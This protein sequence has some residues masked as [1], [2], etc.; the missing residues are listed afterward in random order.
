MIDLKTVLDPGAVTP[1]TAA[2]NAELEAT[3]AELPRMNTFPPEVVRAARAEGKGALPLLGPREGS[4]WVEIPGAPGGPGRVRISEPD[5]DPKGI[6][7]HIHGGGWTIGAADQYDVVNQSLAKD[8]GLRVVSVA[9]RLAPEH[10]WPAQQL[11]CVAAAKWVM[12]TT[13]LPVFI[14]GE[15]A[16]GH[17]TS[18]VALAMRQAGFA[19]RMRGLVMNYGV[20]DLRGTPS[21][22]NWGER[23]LVLSTPVMDWFFDFV[24]PNGEA[25]QRADLSTLL[26]D[27][28]GMP[29][30]LFQ[31]GTEDPLLDDT[32]FMAQRWQAAGNTTELE[33]FPG[34]VH[35][36]DMFLDLEIAKQAHAN[37]RQ[38]TNRL[39]PAAA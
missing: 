27:L 31:V 24:D 18:V 8:T 15:S 22:R 35:A 1:E 16:G 20:F 38:F 3:L 9:Y 5:G 33:V 21:A 14:G 36:F 11:D 4:E 25:R 6:Y 29:P 10:P 7:L 13:D 23:Y 39:L 19:D 2:F 30:A 12:E 32:L 17:L 28:D 34:G 26:A 37:V